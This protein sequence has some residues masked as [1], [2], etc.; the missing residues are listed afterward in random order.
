MDNC[1]EGLKHAVATPH[2]VPNT[3]VDLTSLRKL[4]KVDVKDV[5]EAWLNFL[6]KV[7]EKT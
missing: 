2:K 7:K 1:L 4:D 6:L 3:Q 5:G